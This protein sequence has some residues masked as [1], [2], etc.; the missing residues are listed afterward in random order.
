M[1]IR[2][3]I[4]L[5]ILLGAI[6]FAPP[7]H[8]DVYATFQKTRYYSTNR[9]YFL[10]LKENKQATLYRNGKRLQRVWSRKLEELPERLLV[11]NDGKRVVLVDRYYGNGGSPQTPVVTFLDENGNQITS[12]RLG[13]VA[14]LERALLT[15]SA[16]HWCGG[17]RLSPDQQSVLIESY[18][19]KIPWDECIKKVKPEDHGKCWEI[20]PYQQL[21]FTVASGE[22][23]ERIDLAAR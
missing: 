4:S 8:A 16:A 12:H 11:T 18:V 3:R 6:A 14:N 17:A 20:T 19:L 23:I 22:L 13:D 7:V 10:E 15:I 2:K 5:L 1:S 9:R 21:R